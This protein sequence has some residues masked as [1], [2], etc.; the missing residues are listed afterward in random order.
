MTPQFTF[1]VSRIT[2]RSSG[3][4]PTRPLPRLRRVG[5]LL[6]IRTQG[7]DKNVLIFF[8]FVLRC[9]KLTHASVSRRPRL[10][11]RHTTL[12]VRATSRTHAVY[13]L[14]SSIPARLSPV[15]VHP[16]AVPVFFITDCGDDGITIFKTDFEIQHSPKLLIWNS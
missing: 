14:H 12:S 15:E 5:R 13:G 9:C 2:L 4:L 10:Q 3:I 7:P 11:I 16:V 6:E 8:V 1:E